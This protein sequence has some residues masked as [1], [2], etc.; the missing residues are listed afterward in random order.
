MHYI[1]VFGSRTSRGANDIPRYDAGQKF[2]SILRSSPS[3]GTKNQIFGNIAWVSI[4]LL[5]QDQQLL[6]NEVRVKIR[7]V[8]QYR[9]FNT[10]L[11]KNT[12]IDV[13]S[14]A[15]FPRGF[16]YYVDSGTVITNF[17]GFT[18]GAGTSFIIPTDTAVHDTTISSTI[19]ALIVPTENGANPHYK[20]ETDGME[21]TTGDVTTAKNA[22][23]LINVV[24]NPYYAYS[25]YDNN[26]NV[27]WAKITNLPP[28]CKIS[29]FTLNGTLV[30][31]F[32]RDVSNNLITG[33]KT[34]QSIGT[35]AG[36]G[37]YDT[38][39]DWDLKNQ[40][41]VPVASGAYIIHVEAPGLG[42]RALKW[43]AVMRPI[44]LDNY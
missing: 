42:E 3:L 2:V 32:N 23:S 1:Y 40:K 30:R 21:A 31:R 27:M 9:R 13:N 20:F 41:G 24:P 29:I 28:N 19:G 4:P 6:S 14:A 15:G 39:L 22:L 34:G 38:S 8:R 7:V 18:Y 36:S 12:Y 5:A 33:S 37:N 11:D 44:S 16:S 25:S 35:E 43:F 10:N 17:N 26:T